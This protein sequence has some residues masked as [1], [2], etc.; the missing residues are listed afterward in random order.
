[1]CLGINRRE[2]DLMSVDQM[3]ACS[4]ASD[5]EAEAGLLTVIV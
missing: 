4:D 5:P 2:K 3:F 1:M